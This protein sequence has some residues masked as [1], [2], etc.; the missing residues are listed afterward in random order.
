MII[1]IAGTIGAGKGTVVKHLEAQGFS[2]Y[3]SSDILKDLLKERGL[4]AIR[5]NMSALADELSAQYEGGVLSLSHKQAKKEG[6]ENYV[7]ESIHRKEEADYVRSL[8][9]V[10]LGVDTNLEKR[11]ERT[12]ERAEGE[13]DNTT[14][15][16]FLKDAEREDEGKGGGPNIRAV[17]EDADVVIM[18]NG[19][20]DE[21]KTKIEVALTK[22]GY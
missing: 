22:L 14:Y 11:Y 13:K 9:G 1:G 5:E 10:I 17:L 16:Q 3:S 2:H 19:S 8:G 4:P 20:M 7:L 21:L 18:N 15:E 6:L 12:M